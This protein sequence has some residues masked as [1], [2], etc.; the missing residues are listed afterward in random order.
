MPVVWTLADALPFLREIQ[1]L[2]RPLGYHVGLVGSV[3][4]KGFSHNDL[5]MVLYPAS[6]KTPQSKG[7]VVVALVGIGMRRIIRANKS[8]QRGVDRVRTTTSTYGGETVDILFLVIGGAQG[9]GTMAEMIVGGN[10]KA[11]LEFEEKMRERMRASIGDLMPDPVL[12]DMIKRGVEESFFKWRKVPVPGGYGGQ[13][14]DEKPW[15]LVFLEQEMKDTMKRHVYE[16]FV[17]NEAKVIDIVK[18][19]LNQGV[20]RSLLNAI[21]G[22]FVTPLTFLVTNLQNEILMIK[23]KLG[24][25]Q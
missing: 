14:R 25:P 21:E 10:E 16:W 2:V 13:M 18:E 24:M 3:L 6:S 17:A 7:N 5:D 15:V 23:N 1:V 9:G 12:A 8:R 4:T 22:V 11:R 19:T 20:S